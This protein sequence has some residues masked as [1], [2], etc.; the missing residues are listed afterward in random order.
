MN[1]HPDITSPI[2]RNMM[3]LGFGFAQGTYQMLIIV[4]M[5]MWNHGLDANVNNEICVIS[6]DLWLMAPQAT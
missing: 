4:V 1:G 3:K 5:A 6:L 2:V